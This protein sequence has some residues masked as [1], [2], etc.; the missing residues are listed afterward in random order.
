MPA[1][2]FDLTNP[3]VIVRLMAGLFYLPPVL[4]KTW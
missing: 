1:K 4:F 3:L 2:D